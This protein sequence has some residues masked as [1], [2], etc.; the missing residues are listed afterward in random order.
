[1]PME[2]HVYSHG[3]CLLNTCFNS[4]S[5]DRCAT[6]MCIARGCGTFVVLSLWLK[7]VAFKSDQ[8]C[9]GHEMK[10]HGRSKWLSDKWYKSVL[11]LASKLRW[12][13]SWLIQWTAQH[14]CCQ[15]CCWRSPDVAQQSPS[16]L[17]WNRSGSEQHGRPQ[18]ERSGGLVLTRWIP[19]SKRAWAWLAD[20]F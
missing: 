6:T 7:C 15:Q 17:S 3:R 16:C 9:S 5:A 8:L 10:H 2:G 12:L 19:G 18:S 1:M 4:I 13:F 14:P 20:P 11:C